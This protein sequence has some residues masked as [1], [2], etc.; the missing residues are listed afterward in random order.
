MVKKMFHNLGGCM[1]ATA[2]IGTRSARAAKLE[3]FLKF[4]LQ[5]FPWRLHVRD[6]EG[7]SY[8]IGKGQPHWRGDTLHFH[9]K[10][11]RAG[12]HCL[13][14][15]GRELL[16]DFVRNE[17]DITGNMYLLTWTRLYANLEMNLLSTLVQILKNRTF[18]FQNIKQAKVNV[19]SHYDLSEDFFN[20]YLDRTYHSY[21]CGIFQD[22]ENLNVADL[23]KVG[24]GKNDDFD[25]LEKAQY[26]K[27]ADAALFANPQPGEKVL[28]I[29][30]GYGGQLR[31]GA[32]LFPATK[33]VGWTHSKNQ[34]TVGQELLKQ[35][36]NG[37]SI[38]MNYGDYRQEKGLF[39]HVLSTGM[40]CHV[41]VN[42]LV[43]YVKNVRN[44]LQP[45]GRYMH[46]V[47]MNPYS[48]LWLDA[49]CG[50]S[51]CKKYVW[52]GF[53]WYS[54]GYHYNALERHGFRILGER[55]LSKHY[56]KTTAAWYE[57]MMADEERLKELVGEQTFRA[58][59]IYLSGASAG[60]SS[61]QIEVHRI[62]CEAR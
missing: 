38:Q 9:I 37:D 6:W 4:T 53:H 40:A 26:T 1:K 49:H 19:S 45:N 60:F 46:H 14:L 16:E 59:Q 3:S 18:L 13:A 27:F 58:F 28:D 32:E 21:S 41:G 5:E 54:V 31:V 35:A 2:V 22:P 43:P 33:W 55:N 11:E 10:T 57:R 7:V 62:Y 29:G 48:K 47:I 44:L 56:A 42:G 61:N 15:Q 8:S 25:S 17:V 34:I 24:I 51:F 50:V 36:G 20:T 30:C 52:P 39:N 23:T 12:R